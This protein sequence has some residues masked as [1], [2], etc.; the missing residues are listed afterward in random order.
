VLSSSASAP[1]SVDSPSEENDDDEMDEGAQGRAAR[2]GS[3]AGPAGLVSRQ[4]VAADGE[5]G[6]INNLS[7][8]VCAAGL[9][10]SETSAAPSC[11]PSSLSVP[12]RGSTLPGPA[13]AAKTQ[14]GRHLPAPRAGAS[15]GSFPIPS[16]PLPPVPFPAW[17]ERGVLPVTVSG[18]PCVEPELFSGEPEAGVR[19]MWHFRQMHTDGSGT[20]ELASGACHTQWRV[21]L[22]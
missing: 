14:V 8:P 21:A 5:A 7:S 16:N 17:G 2:T 19:A 10:S 15:T 3:Q 20:G 6:T 22:C 11:S 4:P 9:W 13:S 1:L 12:V 18:D